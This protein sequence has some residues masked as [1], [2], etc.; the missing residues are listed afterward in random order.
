MTENKL[1]IQTLQKINKTQQN[2]TIAWFSRFLRHSRE[3]D[4][5]GLFYNAA[6]PTAAE[7]TRS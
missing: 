5:L 4:G 1:K 2:K 7:L 3:R 6:E